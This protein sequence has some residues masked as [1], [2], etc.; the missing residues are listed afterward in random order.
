MDDCIFSALTAKEAVFLAQQVSAALKN[1]GYN[2][3]K[4]LS[5]NPKVI[6]DL[7]EDK[8]SKS[9]LSFSNSDEVCK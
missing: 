9:V 3:M 5:N 4:W 8:L 1:R 7:P 6:V 2:L